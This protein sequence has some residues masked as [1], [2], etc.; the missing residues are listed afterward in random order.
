M[1]SEDSVLSTAAYNVLNLQNFQPVFIDELSEP[2]NATK[3]LCGDDKKCQFDLSVTGK[4]SIAL[5]TKMFGSKF[6]ETRST[7]TTGT[8]TLELCQSLKISTKETQTK[9]K[10]L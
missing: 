7:L 5:E 6:E 3:A 4:E 1:S 9:F 2:T 8:C 10:M